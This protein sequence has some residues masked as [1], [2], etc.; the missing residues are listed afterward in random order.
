MSEDLAR[1]DVAAMRKDG[2]LTAYIKHH[3]A[4][5]RLENAR[6]RGLVLRYPDLAARLTERPFRFPKPEFWTGFVP[7]A[8][9]GQSINTDPTRRV[10]LELIAEAERRQA[11]PSHTPLEEA[12]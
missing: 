11:A 1:E 4:A 10:L 7:P 8:H 12:A 5:A 2:D 9:W 6:R 3:M